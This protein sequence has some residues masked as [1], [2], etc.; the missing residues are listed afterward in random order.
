MAR[1]IFPTTAKCCCKFELTR[2]AVAVY[3]TIEIYLWAIMSIASIFSEFKMI[4]N[5][6]AFKFRNFTQHST[7]YAIVFGSLK[8]QTDG[9]DENIV[10]DDDDL[11]DNEI[12]Q[13]II[14]EKKCLRLRCDCG[15]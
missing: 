14:G 13:G 11:D 3:V 15:D 6:R 2:I 4:E 5:N 10:D 8:A 12:G 1:E 7:Y 9:D